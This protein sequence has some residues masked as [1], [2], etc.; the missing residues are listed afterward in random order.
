M[1]D[2]SSNRPKQPSPAAP[3]NVS[4]E[5]V[6]AVKEKSLWQVMLSSQAFWVTIALV[7]ICV[8]MSIREPRFATEDNFYNITRNFAFIGIMALGATLVIITGG[9]DLSVGSVMGLVAVACGLTLE[10]GYP[11]YAAVAAGLAAGGIA[12]AING[13]LIAYVGLSPFVVTL[14]MLSAA[15]SVAVV[16]SGNKMLYNFGP[17]GPSFKIIGAGATLGIA[18]PV[19]VLVILTLAMVVVMRMTTWGRHLLAI[20]GN[21]H[22]ANLTGVPVKRIKLQAYVF[23]G[24]SGAIASILSVGWAGSA[25]NSLGAGYELRAIASTVIGGANLMG[26][27]GG[28]LGAF[29]GSALLEVIRNSLLMAGVDS[30]WQGVFVGSFLVLAV[31]LERIRGKRRE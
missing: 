13:G 25:I 16:L 5:S 21:E 19:W 24:L 28:A 29:I 6:L 2:A 4:I 10:A 7:V 27:E 20:G 9:I 15:R 17:G 26:G 30:N 1:T 31:L 3:S 12:G 14:G 8:I 18:N 22:A 23:S 11:W